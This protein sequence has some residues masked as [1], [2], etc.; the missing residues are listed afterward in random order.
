ML[1]S[2]R[3]CFRQGGRFP[4]PGQN[5]GPPQIPASGPFWGNLM[6]ESLRW[7]RADGRYDRNFLD[8]F[9]V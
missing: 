8:R 2:S 6:L 3:P 5:T 9:D 4:V 1:G 7:R